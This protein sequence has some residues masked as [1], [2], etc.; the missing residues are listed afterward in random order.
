[1]LWARSAIVCGPVTRSISPFTRLYLRC[2]RSVARRSSGTSA[3][4]SCVE[5]TWPT[6]S[7]KSVTAVT[8]MS[9]KRDVLTGSPPIPFLPERGVRSFLAASSFQ[10]GSPLYVLGCLAGGRVT[11]RAAGLLEDGLRTVYVRA[12]FFVTTD[13][14]ATE[15]LGRTAATARGPGRVRPNEAGRCVPADSALLLSVRPPQAFCGVP[16]S[17]PADS[18]TCRA[19]GHPRSCR[20]GRTA[21]PADLQASDS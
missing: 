21:C 10:P 3:S 1:M 20:C 16:S 2:R 8:S 15:L 19:R 13:I 12:G 17:R 4:N 6:Y 9:T 14:E 7:V 5:C 18:R 11:L